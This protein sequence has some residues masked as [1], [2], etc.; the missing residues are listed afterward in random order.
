MYTILCIIGMQT[1][2]TIDRRQDN[3][4]N[5]QKTI[6]NIILIGLSLMFFAL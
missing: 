1:L 4:L 3:I 5:M 6:I 2:K